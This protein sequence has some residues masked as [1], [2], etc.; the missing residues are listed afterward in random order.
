M[1][2]GLHT[3]A[4]SEQPKAKSAIE[5]VGRLQSEI[6]SEAHVLVKSAADSNRFE[7][8]KNARKFTKLIVGM[9]L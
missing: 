7:N 1:S 3:L 2:K 4:R 9:A 6:Q 8:E 5:N